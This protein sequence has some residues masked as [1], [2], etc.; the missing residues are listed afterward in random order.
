M[1]TLSPSLYR[2]QFPKRTFWFFANSSEECEQ[3]VELL[4]SKVMVSNILVSYCTSEDAY[5]LNS[6]RLRLFNFISNIK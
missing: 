6:L 3:W 2:V 5:S 1:T 4:R